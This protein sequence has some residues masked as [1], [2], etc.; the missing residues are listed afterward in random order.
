MDFE[1]SEEQQA[2]R[3]LARQIFEDRATP[4]RLKQVEV[5]DVGIDA[6]LW[7][8]LAKAN[9]VGAALADSVGGSGLGLLGLCVLLEEAGRAVA[10]V[11]LW[12]VLALGAFPLAELG[13]EAQQQRWLPRVAAG[14]VFLSGGFEESLCDDPSAPAALA[15]PDGAGYRLDGVKTSVPIAHLAARIVVPARD[16]AGEL[17]V[18]LLDPNVS[19]VTL[20]RQQATNREPRFRV[21]LTG[22]AIAEED[23]LCRPATAPD[24]AR[25]VDLAITG[26]CALQVGVADRALRMTA[27]YMTGRMQFGR[28]IGSFQ[29]AHQRAAD[30]YIDVEAMRL[31]TWQAACLLASRQPAADAVSV[32]KFWASEGGH[33][34]VYAAQHLHGGIGVDVDYPIHRYYLSARQIELTLGGAEYHLERLGNLY[35]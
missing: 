10:P 16:A 32:A 13:S 8:E 28:P 25:C 5:S 20:E 18:F 30:S 11:P 14:E 12:P 29:A 22:A 1:F 7:A 6:D 15:S 27:E 21:E 33:R 31:T 26:L 34:V 2:V 35:G 4:D 9:L 19:G 17:G 23:V 24:F 3:D